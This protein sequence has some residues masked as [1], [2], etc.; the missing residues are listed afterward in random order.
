MR[1]PWPANNEKMIKYHDEEWG[2]P[3]HDDQL[4]FEHLALDGFQA[5]LSWQ[6]I[7]NKRENFRKAFANFNIAVVAAFDSQK[8]EELLQDAGI[9]RNRLKIEA[10]INN[11]KRILEVQKEFGSFDQYLWCF[12]NNRSLH[13]H[14]RELSELPASTPLSDT[15]SKD[16]RK[17]GFKFVGSTIVYAFMQAVGMVNDHLTFCFRYKEIIEF[18]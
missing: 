11:A 18:R 10:A 8:V 16:L 3:V 1:C 7:L 4:L 13:N 15:I 5:G 14:F 2:V 9:I 6:T 17:R 12:T